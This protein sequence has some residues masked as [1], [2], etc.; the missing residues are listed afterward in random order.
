M[1]LDSSHTREP[2]LGHP[3]HPSRKRTFRSL[4]D[5]D[6]CLLTTGLAEGLLIFFCRVKIFWLVS[7][8]D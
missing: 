5:A 8:G 3:M 4:Q 1:N 7:L 6:E 2:H